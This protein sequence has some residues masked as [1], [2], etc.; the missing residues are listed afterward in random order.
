MDGT[1]QS[2][3]VLQGIAASPGIAHGQ[4]FVL[5][6]KEVEVPSYHIEPGQRDHEIARFEQA[7][8]ATRHQI[9]RVQAEIARDLGDDEAR[10]FD[11]HLLVLED[12]ALIEE[13]I[14]EMDKSGQ[15][16]DACFH[17]VGKRYAEAFDRIDDEYLRERASD[18]RD[19]VRRVLHNLTGQV[20][21]NISRLAEHRVLVSHDISPSDSASIDRARVLGLVTDAGSKTSHAVIVARSM[22]I[23]AVVGLRDVTSRLQ[24]GDWII[25]DGYEGLVI[26][27][28]S[29]Q[30]LFRYGKIQLQ[31]RNVERKILASAQRPAE[32]LDG[33]RISLLAN[34]E[35]PDECDRVREAGAEGVGL[36][37][38]EFLFLNASSVPSEDVQ[39]EAYR[40]VAEA[41]APQPVVIRTLD[42]GGDKPNPVAA[43]VHGEANP[44]LGFRAI[45]LCLENISLFK[46]QLRAILRAS[47]FGNVKVMYPMISGAEEL[48]KAN[49]VMEEAKDELRRRGQAFSPDL[50]IGSMIEIP[51]A[52]LTCDILAKSCDFFSIGTNDLI[53]YLLAID[54]G[55]ERIANLYEPSHPAV[56]RMLKMIVE[57]GHAAKI[58]V[59]VC[60]EMAGDPIYV[61]LLL[62]MGVDELSISSSML[63]AVK[64]LVQNMKLTDAVKLSREAMRMSDPKEIASLARQFVQ[65]RMAALG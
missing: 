26:A 37:R 42:L 55:N 21:V 19:V 29:E 44:F 9:T 25:V 41:M 28:P 45:R 27:H 5:A 63:P 43:A 31:R 53:Q 51:S 60:G 38:T 7:L 3:L 65:D 47:A 62:G 33:R 1:P 4:V 11:A 15:N 35:S 8:L 24:H 39:F 48:A 14:R 64:Y 6:H 61:P 10:I 58:K 20:M 18:I 2:D 12:Q 54:R 17:E 13:T 50:E 46:D 57:A 30:T 40:R 22:K 23:P 32:T 36:F 49:A 34:I 56:L 16:I 52:A 59:S